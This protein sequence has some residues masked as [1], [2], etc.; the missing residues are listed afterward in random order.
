MQGTRTEK[1]YPGQSRKNSP[2]QAK[3]GRAGQAR[4]EWHWHCHK[5]RRALPWAAWKLRRHA[6]MVG[7]LPE[8]EAILQF[9]SKIQVN[10]LL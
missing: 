8:K 3:Q 2:V 10:Q 5:R 1:D 4:E 7:D 9:L 6:Q